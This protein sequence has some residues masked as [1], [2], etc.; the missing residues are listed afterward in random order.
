MRLTS[1]LQRHI[2]M[3]MFIF[4]GKSIF[5]FLLTFIE[6]SKISMDY[7]RHKWE[8]GNQGKDTEISPVSIQFG[9]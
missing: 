8:C 3:L 4:L 7:L 2:N 9:V 6:L 5:F 1:I